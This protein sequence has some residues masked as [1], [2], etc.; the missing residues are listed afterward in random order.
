METRIL[1]FTSP[2]FDLSVVLG[3]IPSGNA[4]FPRLLWRDV[5]SF[6]FSPRCFHLPVP[7]RRRHLGSWHFILWTRWDCLPLHGVRVEATSNVRC[8]VR[9]SPLGSR[10]VRPT[11]AIPSLAHEIQGH[12]IKS[13]SRISILALFRYSCLCE[14]RQR[15]SRGP[16]GKSWYRFG[17]HLLPEPPYPVRQ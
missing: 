4:V 16:Q 14:W 7:W 3:I 13:K 10:H 6:P 12:L 11:I 5:S 9:A 8:P 1:D 2:S 15:L 17:H